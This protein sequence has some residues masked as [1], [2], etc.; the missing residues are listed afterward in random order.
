MLL[1]RYEKIK[2]DKKDIKTV[3]L[4]TTKFIK[5]YDEKSIFASK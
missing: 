3:P 5:E 2:N 4:R 1:I